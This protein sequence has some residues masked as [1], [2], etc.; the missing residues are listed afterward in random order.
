[1]D[2]TY[3]KDK[4]VSVKQNSERQRDYTKVLFCMRVL[5]CTDACHHHHTCIIER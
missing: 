4:D 3:A 1:M 2:I 5:V